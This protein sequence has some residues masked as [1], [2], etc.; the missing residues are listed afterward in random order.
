MIRHFVCSRHRFGHGVHSP[1]MYN[2]FRETLFNTSKFDYSSAENIQALCLKNQKVINVTPAGA[3]LQKN[4]TM[5]RICD[6]AASSSS[7]GK[8]GRL[9]QRISAYLKPN[10]ILELGTS[11][12]IGTIYLASGS[13]KSKIVTIE[14]CKAT[15]NEARQNFDNIGISSSIKSINANFDE[16]LPELIS[17]EKFE[18]IYID[19]NHTYE[20]TLRYYNMI[21]QSA[22]S[23]T[24]AI[25]DDINWSRGMSAAWSK[26]CKMPT[27]IAAIETMRM[28]IV[29]FDK[30]LTQ[31]IYCTR[32]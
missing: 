9:L 7:Y 29:F 18:L 4:D 15:C 31:K 5:R 10:Q 14:A 12:G 22:A 8:Y 30:N 19:G 2:F 24:V 23:S 11:L 28:G 1:N 6:I 16:V 3:S 21:A 17:N 25:F 27:T 32:F 26:I 20:A 13:P